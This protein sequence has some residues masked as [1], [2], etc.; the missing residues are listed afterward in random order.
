MW[1]NTTKITILQ[2]TS[3]WAS[4]PQH[5]TYS[6]ILSSSK[7]LNDPHIPHASSS[8]HTLYA[9]QT[10]KTYGNLSPHHEYKLAHN[11]TS[12]GTA[13]YN[14]HHLYGALLRSEYY[15]TTGQYTIRVLTIYT[16][17]AAKWHH[18]CSVIS[19]IAIAPCIIIQF[20][21]YLHS[22]NVSRR[23]YDGVFAYLVWCMFRCTFWNYIIILTKT[24]YR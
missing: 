16:H 21:V 9:K 2:T 23:P 12:V 17:T 5:V 14:R 10:V 1:H 6:D 20:N 4:P 7:L 3:T 19:Y 13:L 15:M 24:C 8:Q 18:A 11:A 22:S